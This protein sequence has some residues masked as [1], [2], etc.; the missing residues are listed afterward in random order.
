MKTLSQTTR[1]RLTAPTTT[2][3][4][5]W[6]VTRA[7]G[8]TLGF[9]DHDRPVAFDGLTYRPDLGFETTAAT[10]E[11]DLA[12]GSAEVS[13]I[14]ASQSLTEADLAAGLWDGAEVEVFTV[15][16]QDPSARVLMRLAVIGEVRREGQAFRAE[17]RGLAHLFDQP[18]GRV[19]SH[20][21]D[22]DL[23]DARCRV[24]LDAGG[25]RPTATLAAGSTRDTLRLEGVA[26]PEADWFTGGRVEVTPDAGPAIV[27][28][29]V[30]DRRD[31]SERVVTLLGPLPQ[32]PEPA[33][34]I[35]LVAGCDK[36]F[37]TCREKFANAPNFQGF[38]HM[39][40]A[41]FVLAYPSRGDAR[42]DGGRLID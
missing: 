39:P 22:A 10:Q 8:L 26:G 28:E 20:L 12:A 17:L 1:D 34:E 14:L 23:G 6:R 19:F 16:W 31:G 21:C 4:T 40:G 24:D 38:P 18:Q 11:P 27:R 35:R 25:F 32:V 36:R 9:T 7:D 30:S 5:C 33:W 3:A 29:I 42:N 2:R 37:A 15:D 13:G 41:D